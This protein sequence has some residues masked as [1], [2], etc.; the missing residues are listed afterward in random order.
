VAWRHLV[1]DD[2]NKTQGEQSQAEDELP[3][4]TDKELADQYLANWQRSQAD[5]INFKKRAEQEKAEFAK[6]ANSALMSSL[7]PIIDDFERALENVPANARN[8]GWLEGIKL[9]YQKLMAVLENQGLSRIE[10]KGAD[11]DPNFHE[12][13]LYEEGEEGKVLEELQKGYMLHDRLL[14]PTMVKVGKGNNDEPASD[15][16]SQK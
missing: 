13:V 7:L 4:P 11:F 2:E 1:A 3:A 12:A 16:N 15:N 8:A 5:F 6:F 10:A 9:I 14:R